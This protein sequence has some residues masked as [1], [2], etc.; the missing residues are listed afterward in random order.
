MREVNS[1][2]DIESLHRAGSGFQYLLEGIRF[3]SEVMKIF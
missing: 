3:L 2:G 1:I